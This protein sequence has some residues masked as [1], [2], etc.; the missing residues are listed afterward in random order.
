[1]NHPKKNI[2]LPA[3]LFE[4]IQGRVSRINKEGEGEGTSTDFSKQVAV[5]VR[6][7]MKEDAPQYG[8]EGNDPP[9]QSKDAATPA[10]RTSVL[11]S[12]RKP[13]TKTR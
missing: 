7:L 1:M 13:Q 6:L 11:Y 5:A 12:S 4:Y 8:G 2:S 10:A 9:P 3:D